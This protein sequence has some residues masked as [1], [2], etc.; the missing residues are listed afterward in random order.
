MLQHSCV[1]QNFWD[2]VTLNCLHS[3]DIYTNST[4]LVEAPD[5]SN[6][7]SKY[8]KFTNIFNKTKA[9]VLTSHHPYDLQINP[10]EDTHPLIGPI[11][12]L[13][14]SEQEVLKEFIEK[15]LNIGFIWPISSL[16][17]IP[18][19]FIKKKDSLLCL[20]IDFHS[21][22]HIF[23]KNCYPLLLISNLLDL[24]YK[25]WVYIKIDLYHTY[26]LVHIADSDK[27]KTAF[28]TYYRL[29]KWSVIFFGLIN[30]P[31][32]FQWF[33]NNIFSNILN[34]CVMIYLDD[35]LIYSNN[36]S[37]YHWHVKEVLKCLWKTSLYTKVE[38][39]K[40]HFKLVEYLGYI[41]SPSGLTMSNN[42]VKIIQDWPKP[43]KVKDIQFFLGFAN[44]YHWF[45]FNYLD[46]ITP[47]TYLIWKDIF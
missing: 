36:M 29:F 44:F 4:K 6:I 24:P 1:Y 41:L 42:K 30:T 23:K 10:K 40:F 22:N 34:V 18:V 37:E 45:I 43:K 35:I 12:S 16:H 2:L 21:F 32:A 5:L 28:R 46:I 15:N 14:I 11:Y 7:P 27:W 38:K 19:L 47:L 20:Y 39:C 8:H 9:E 3:L 25:A 17:S 26:H 13:L 31:M 33:I